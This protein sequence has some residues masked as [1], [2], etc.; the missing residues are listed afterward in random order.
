THY[1]FSIK[2]CNPGS[3]HEKGNVENKVGTI[4]RNLFVP[5][6]TINHLGTFNLDL[7]KKCSERNQGQ[8][9]RLKKSIDA[10]FEQEKLLMAPVNKI[11]FDTARYES[12]KVNKFGLVEFG[13]CRYSA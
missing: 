8:H 3:G 5:E 10:L 7:L 2:F 13:G 4:R 1:G 6:P 11:P 9:Y 12:R